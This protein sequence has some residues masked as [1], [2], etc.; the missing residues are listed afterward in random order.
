MS[1]VTLPYGFSC[2]NPER[3]EHHSRETGDISRAIDFLATKSVIM[4][5]LGVK[6]WGMYE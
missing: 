3:E 1:R 6:N 2:N 4:P 5:A